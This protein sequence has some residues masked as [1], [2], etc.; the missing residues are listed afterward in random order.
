M[1]CTFKWIT[2][3]LIILTSCSKTSDQSFITT[4]CDTSFTL[5]NGLCT[6]LYS[7]PQNKNDTM[8]DIETHAYCFRVSSAA[9]ICKIGYQNTSP[10]NTRPYLME[11]YDSSNNSLLYS[12]THVLGTQAT[13][14]VSI[15]PVN[16]VPGR[17]YLIKRT[18]PYMSNV[19]DL[20]GRVVWN[21]TA[22]LN[23]PM[24]NGPFSITSSLFTYS[25]GTLQ[26]YEY[27]LPYI[28][29]VFE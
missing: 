4:G 14:Y 20:I 19:M 13:T 18:L 15:P 26:V 12:G 2:G 23:F 11:I 1:R 5:F 27:M 6:A 7:N 29:I 21:Q 25:N 3:L 24:A 22:P 8:M 17:V 28:D 10:T 16:L 9:T